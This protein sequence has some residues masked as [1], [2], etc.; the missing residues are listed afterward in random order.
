MNSTK[1]RGLLVALTASP[2]AVRFLYKKFHNRRRRRLHIAKKVFCDIFP[3][4]D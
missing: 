1:R 2:L 4:R 3:P